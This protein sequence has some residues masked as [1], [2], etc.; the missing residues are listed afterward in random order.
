MY[1]RKLLLHM[2][3]YIKCLVWC[4]V[5]SKHSHSSYIIINHVNTDIGFLL[6]IHEGGMI[7]MKGRLVLQFLSCSPAGQQCYYRAWLG[8]VT[9]SSEERSPWQPHQLRPRAPV[10]SRVTAS[11]QQP[12]RM[13]KADLDALAEELL[14]DPCLHRNHVRKERE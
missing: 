11:S 12:V 13:A 5:Q 9:L 3:T 7:L 6:K 4:L 8:M 10:L 2:W 1:V 14:R